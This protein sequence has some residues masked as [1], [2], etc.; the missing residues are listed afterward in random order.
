MKIKSGFVLRNV[1]G[2]YV[3]VPIGERSCELHGMICLN[4]SGAFL[5]EKAQAETDALQLC[6]ALCGEYDVSGDEAM[7]AVLEF[8]EYLRSEGILENE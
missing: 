6:K 3:A 5:F 4:E 1:A 7:Q 8:I 2:K